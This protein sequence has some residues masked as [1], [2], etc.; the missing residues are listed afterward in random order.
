MTLEQIWIDQLQKR[1]PHIDL[2]HDTYFDE[3]SRQILTTDILVEGTHFSWEY[4]TP[5]DLGWK[6]IAVNLSDIAATGGQPRWALVSI[7][8]PEENSLILLQGVY[9]GIDACCQA[10]GLTLIGGDTVRSQE[11]VVSVTLI[12]QLSKQA[13][14]GRR[15]Q[16][17]PRD[18]LAVSGSHGLSKT[19]LEAL[20]KGLTG[21]H[22]AKQAHLRPTPQVRLG[23]RIS[24]VMP[25]YAMMDSSDGLADAACRLAMASQVDIVIEAGRLEIHPEVQE[26]ASQTP[27]NPKDWVLYGGEDFQLVVSLPPETVGLFPEL[28]P[29]GYVQPASTPGKGQAFF[30]DK[31][32]ITPIQ[33]DKA[34]QHFE[35]A[36]HEVGVS[37]LEET[38]FRE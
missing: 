11:T 36:Q 26:L 31:Q 15:N 24:T 16:A 13:V 2:R 5:F 21:F 14:P 29:V 19:G 23:Q 33:L 8:V 28:Q 27:N 37:S 7:G 3:Q 20:Q 12:G 9:E 4:F 17:Q 25:R 18:I 1:W 30:R 22:E 35:E 6:S 38:S 32:R 10:F 34:F